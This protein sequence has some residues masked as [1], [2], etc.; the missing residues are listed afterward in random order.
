[1]PMLSEMSWSAFTPFGYVFER[2]AMVRAKAL[3]LP[4]FG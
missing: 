1:L 2:P 3:I 4:Y